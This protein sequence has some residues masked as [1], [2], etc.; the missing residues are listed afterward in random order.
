MAMEMFSNPFSIHDTYLWWQLD[1]MYFP[2]SFTQSEGQ[3]DLL[4]WF[5]HHLLE[6]EIMPT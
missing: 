2:V 1:R 3:M 6:Y 5:P 4:S